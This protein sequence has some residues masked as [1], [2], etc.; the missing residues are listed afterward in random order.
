MIEDWGDLSIF[1]GYDELDLSGYE[2]KE[3]KIFDLP[4]QNIN[5]LDLDQLL[6]EGYGFVK[7]DSRSIKR[8]FSSIP[9]NLI[10]DHTQI[11]LEPRYNGYANFTIWKDKKLRYNVINGFIYDV[12]SDLELKN[13]GLIF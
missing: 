6:K 5:E 1:Y 4:I 7:I 9:F 3:S 8:E 12:N 11:N 2:I 13:N 10:L